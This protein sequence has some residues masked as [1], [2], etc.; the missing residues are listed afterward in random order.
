MKHK[1]SWK[2][3]ATKNCV[4]QSQSIVSLSLTVSE[5]DARKIRHDRSC[6]DAQCVLAV[7]RCLVRVCVCVCV[8]VYAAVLLKSFRGD[9]VTQKSKEETFAFTFVD[10]EKKREE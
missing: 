6:C 7:T 5:N 9:W 4:F 10:R 2:N 1:C 3:L 8:C